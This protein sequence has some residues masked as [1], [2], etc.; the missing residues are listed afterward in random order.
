MQSASNYRANQS[1]SLLIQGPPKSRKTSLALHFPNP[2]VLDADN[3]MGGTIRWM[4]RNN[5][6]VDKIRY[7][8]P[9]IIVDDKGNFVSERPYGDRYQFTAECLK[10]AAADPTIDTVIVDGLSKI[11]AY[12]IG[13]IGRQKPNIGEKS[14]KKRREGQ[15]SLEDWTDHLF[16]V[17][18]FITKLQAIP[19]MFILTCHEEVSDRPDLPGVLVSISGKKAQ[20]QIAGMFSDIWRTYIDDKITS[21]GTQHQWMLQ[22]ASS[23]NFQLAN[24]LGLPDKM[25]FDWPTISKALIE[26]FGTKQEVKAA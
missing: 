5:L 15:M 17:Q 13:D 23:G 21:T 4:R 20:A 2:Y 9:D 1:F 26:D 7:D 16:M 22:L 25:A 12:I 11:N 18:N 6:P 14:P 24:S 10:A 8:V 19:K 3:N